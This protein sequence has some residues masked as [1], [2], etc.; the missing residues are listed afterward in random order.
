M[1]VVTP[2]TRATDVKGLRVVD[3]SIIPNVKS[4]NTNIRTI[5][6]VERAADLIQNNSETNYASFSILK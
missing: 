6:M 5:V 1:T 4:G 3:A 2:N